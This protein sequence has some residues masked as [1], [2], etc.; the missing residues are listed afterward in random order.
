MRW[1]PV[2]LTALAC[3]DVVEQD[4][5]DGCLYGL[6][7]NGDG[8]CDR[9]AA[10]WSRDAQVPDGESRANIFD[11][12]AD[13]LPEVAR[14]GIRH[15]T[16]WPITVSGMLLPYE[17]VRHFLDDPADNDEA[18]TYKNLVGSLLGFSDLQGLYDQVGV[19]PFNDASATGIYDIEVPPGLTRDDRLGVTILDTPDGTALTFSCAACHAGRLLGRTVMGLTNRQPRANA[20]FDLG[21]T[22]L[23]SMPDDVFQRVTGA[24][25]GEIGMLARSRTNLARVGV[26]DPA[27]LG[28]DTSLAQVAMSL[29]QRNADAYATPSATFEATPRPN[30]LTS[31][32]ADSKPMP[33]W[34]LKHKTRWLSDGSIVSGNPIFTNFL[35][36]EIGRGTDLKELEDWLTTNRKVADELTVAVF[37]NT[38]PP[39]TDFF[40]ASGLDLASAQ[41]G[42][43]L[44]ADHCS[45]C[46]GTYD[47]GWDAADASSRTPEALLATTAVHYHPSTPVMD[48]GTSLARADGMPAFAERLNELAISA[49]MQTTVEVQTGYVPPPLDGIWARYPYLHNN[50]VPTLCAL[51]SPVEARPTVFWQGPSEEAADFDA[52]CVGYPTGEA[53]PAGWD[54]IEGARFDTSRPGMSNEGHTAMLTAANGDW[55]L[56]DDDRVDLIAFLKT[57]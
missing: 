20:F 28:L 24:T 54:G 5:D 44:F 33:W 38:P 15:A 26:K 22:V 21:K 34:T 55:L 53:V 30:A 8:V 11:L 52:D 41:R 6:D 13:Q 23:P 4:V 16:Q 35:W 37:A 47:K 18:Q 1:L 32:V 48:V 17:P 50:S 46:H 3:G 14:H 29:S 40:D 2:V 49:W 45:T 43:A 9:L 56:S 36:N 12:D 25:E 57:L 19:P 7:A 10:D 39:W 42:Q 27:A 51:L 31:H